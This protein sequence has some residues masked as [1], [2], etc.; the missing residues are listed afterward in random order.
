MTNHIQSQIGSNE[1]EYKL[2]TTRV[3]MAPKKCFRVTLGQGNLKK[4]HANNMF[5]Y[6]VMTF[7]FV[8]AVYLTTKDWKGFT[9]PE[10]VDLGAISVPTHVCRRKHRHYDR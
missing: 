4:F 6:T 10:E 3:N 8:L 9:S 2:Y 5:I 7:L 1:N